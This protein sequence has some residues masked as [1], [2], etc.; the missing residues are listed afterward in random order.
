MLFKTN[1]IKEWLTWALRKIRVLKSFQW[2]DMGLSGTSNKV[3]QINIF[4]VS[5]SGNIFNWYWSKW[6]WCNCSVRNKTSSES[7]SDVIIAEKEGGHLS[8]AS[9]RHQH[10]IISA[11]LATS[12]QGHHPESAAWVTESLSHHIWTDMSQV[13][14]GSGDQAASRTRRSVEN[15]CFIIEL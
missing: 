7:G 8:G 4:L 12:D 13:R 10:P 11:A 3:H 2:S 6:R 14:P 9:S 15:Y 5:R 1:P